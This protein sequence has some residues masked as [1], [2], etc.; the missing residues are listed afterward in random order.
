MAYRFGTRNMLKFAK[1]GYD[2]NMTWTTHAT[3]KKMFPKD[4]AVFS[5]LEM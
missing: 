5:I 4:A 3:K 2:L 1:H